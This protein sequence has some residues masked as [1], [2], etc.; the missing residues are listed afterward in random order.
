MQ[1]DARDVG[2]IPTWKDPLEEEMAP[3]S[4]WELPGKFHGQRSLAGYSSQGHKELD[5]TEHIQHSTAQNQPDGRD[6]EGV[7]CGKGLGLSYSLQEFHS[8][9]ISTCSP[10]QGLYEL[11]L[12]DFYGGS[13][14]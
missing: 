9:K 11:C 6:L 8:P 12:W 13:I 3:N 7:L 1:E 14:L 5:M 2:S 4:S 10:N